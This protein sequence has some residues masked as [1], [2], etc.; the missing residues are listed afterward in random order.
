MYASG[1]CDNREYNFYTRHSLK[2]IQL[3]ALKLCNPGL[4]FI[5]IVESDYRWTQ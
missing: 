1:G 5:R 3:L 4:W 2:A